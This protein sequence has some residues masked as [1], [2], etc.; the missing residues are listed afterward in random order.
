MNIESAWGG[1]NIH[2]S[3]SRNFAHYSIYYHATSFPG[4][5]IQTTA[6]QPG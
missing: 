5:F 1:F 4:R 2:Y 3:K 6:T